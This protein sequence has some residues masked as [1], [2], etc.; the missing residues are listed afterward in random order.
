MYRPPAAGLM[1]RPCSRACFASNG[2]GQFAKRVRSAR[3]VAVPGAYSLRTDLACVS[4]TVSPAPG[5]MPLVRSQRVP[6]TKATSSGFCRPQ[7]N[8]RPAAGAHLSAVGWAC[9]GCENRNAAETIASAASIGFIG[10][11]GSIPPLVQ[12]KAGH[13]VLVG[14]A[15]TDLR[16]LEVD[17]DSKDDLR[18]ALDLAGR[19]IDPL[20]DF[21]NVLVDDRMIAA[22][23]EQ[24]DQHR[25]CQRLVEDR[26]LRVHVRASRQGVPGDDRHELAADD[27]HNLRQKLAVFQLVAIQ[28]FHQLLPAMDDDL[29]GKGQDSQPLERSRVQ[30]Q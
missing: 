23:G 3:V 29:F 30:L 12:L 15:A 21:P 24:I 13:Y 28:P 22:L 8:V 18:S 16:R 9:S 2:P 27:L 6:G 10:M 4:T 17:L 25:D 7:M 19:Q 1:A 11:T 14:S 20:R 26:V 5:A